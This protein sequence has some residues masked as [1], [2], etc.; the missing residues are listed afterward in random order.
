VGPRHCAFSR[1]GRF[2]YVVNEMGGSVC[3]FAYD[4]VRGAL[5]L[6]QTLSTLPANF[7]G[8][9]GSAEIQTHP[10]GRFVYASNRGEENDSSLAV[11]ARDAESGALTLVQVMTTDVHY[12]RSFSISPD[13][14]WL[15]CGNQETDQLA[16]FRVDPASGRLAPTGRHVSIGQPVCVLFYD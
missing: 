12:P 14:R 11:L 10:N 5:A 16:L 8:V 1:D 15:L 2:L 7:H 4:P 6:R 3:V 9:N 13:G